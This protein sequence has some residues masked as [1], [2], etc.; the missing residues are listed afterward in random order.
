[1]DPKG[2]KFKRSDEQRSDYLDAESRVRS[3]NGFGFFHNG[4][5]FQRACDRL[6]T[7]FVDVRLQCFFNIG[8]TALCF[9]KFEFRYFVLTHDNPPRMF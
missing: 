6:L 1:M 8:N 9:R 4:I 2:G 7:M 5:G 3:L